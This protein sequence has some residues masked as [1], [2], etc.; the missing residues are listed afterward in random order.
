MKIWDYANH[1]P[2]IKKTTHKTKYHNIKTNISILFKKN[3]S[4][5]KLYLLKQ[6]IDLLEIKDISFLERPSRD[7]SYYFEIPYESKIWDTLFID[8]DHY[9]RI[10]KWLYKY[11]KSWTIKI[12]NI[13]DV[14]FYWYSYEKNLEI[15]KKL[16][17]YDKEPK[18]IIKLLYK[19][20]KKNKYQM[21]NYILISFYRN[22]N[23]FD[24]TIKWWSENF[25]NIKWNFN[26]GMAINWYVSFYSIFEF[27]HK[28]NLINKLEEVKHL[29]RKW[30]IK[31]WI[32]PIIAIDTKKDIKIKSKQPLAIDL[33]NITD[34][35][36]DIM[37]ELVM[38]WDID[39]RRVIFIKK[40]EKWPFYWY[41]SKSRIYYS[42]DKILDTSVCYSI[43]RTK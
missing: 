10:L 25:S 11:L 6:Y 33:Y 29:Y 1:L 36:F 13:A 20:W 27:T 32:I 23:M 28:F 12:S 4:I 37:Y 22:W 16:K 30:I 35:Q 21:D 24:S 31:F 5:S 39:M 34:I 41:P 7:L 19:E 26:S 17:R 14:P 38:Q 40:D 9:N 43:M 8:K 3:V 42:E 2:T 15:H 18:K